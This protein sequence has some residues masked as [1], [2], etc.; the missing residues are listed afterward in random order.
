MNIYFSFINFSTGVAMIFGKTFIAC[1][2][3]QLERD[4]NFHEVSKPK[5]SC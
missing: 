3:N 2:E 5:C 4:E 1:L